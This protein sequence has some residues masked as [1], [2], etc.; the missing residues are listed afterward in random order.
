MPHAGAK[1]ALR[2]A[3]GGE[4]SEVEAPSDSSL[5]LLD[6]PAAVVCAIC[7]DP[8]CLGDCQIEEHTQTSGIV[9]IVPWER[10]GGTAPRLWGTAKLSTL[11][12]ESFF[13]ALPDGEI[14]AP[15]RFALLAEA[16]AVLGMGVV[17]IPILLAF[18][19]WLLD[20]VS[21]DPWLRAWLVK[22]LSVGIPGLAV[23]MVVLHSVHGI[24]LDLGARHN[25]AG[26]R[27]TRGLRFGLYSCGWDL[28][29]LPAGI[30]MLAVT[31]GFRAARRAMPLSLTVPKL[32][33]R[34]FLRGAYQLDEAASVRASKRAMWIAG[35]L[36][37][38][39]CL[40]FGVGM[41]AL[42]LV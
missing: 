12:A 9:A 2:D 4:A 13:A 6:V 41:V 17:A 36:A 29:T 15:L 1:G 22:L 3:Q 42:A 18:A 30:G 21:R 40:L 5:E 34:A 32:A 33:S 38:V 11:S 14:A 24:S 37:L 35:A 19:P 23:L 26:A 39:A 31:D 28:I 10:P 25:G 27:T 20:A 16:L 7:G 8:A